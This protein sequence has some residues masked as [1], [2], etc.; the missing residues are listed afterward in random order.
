M[1]SDETAAGIPAEAIEAYKR[2][3]PA[4]AAEST[5]TGDWTEGDTGDDEIA[6]AGVAADGIE[7]DDPPAPARELTAA[8]QSQH[9]AKL[10]DATTAA[11]ESLDAIAKHQ[12][13]RQREATERMLAPV[14]T[15]LRDA[16]ELDH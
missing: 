4:P 11:I 2:D 14:V 12:P 6:E 15:R 1:F 3:H 13:D 8:E 5:L 9:Y 7:A 10:L 16:L